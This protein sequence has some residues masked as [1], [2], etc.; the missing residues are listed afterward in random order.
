MLTLV[1]YA[2]AALLALLPTRLAGVVMPVIFLGQRILF[3]EPEEDLLR[4]GSMRI[5][6]VDVFSATLVLKWLAGGGLLRLREQDRGIRYV[7]GAWAAVNFLA[8]LAAG[9]KF[10]DAHAYACIAS[11]ARGLGEAIL[12]VVLADSFTS[13]RQARTV[14]LAILGFLGVLLAIQF[15]NYAGAD[16][17]WVIGEVQGLERDQVRIFG[18][19]GDSVGF[20]LL[21]GY[22]YGLCRENLIV[23]AAFAGGIVVTAG[24]GAVI[25]MAVAT[26]FYLVARPYLAAAAPRRGAAPLLLGLGLAA[27]AALVWTTPLTATLRERLSGA[28]EESGGQRALTARVALTMVDDNFW[29]GVGFMGFRHLVMRYGGSD[30]FGYDA[31]DGGT[32]NANN[33]ALQSLTDAGIPGIVA[34]AALIFVAARL[35]YRV[36]HRAGDPVLAAFFSAVMLWLLA[37]AFG[38]L[39]ATWLTPSSGVALLLWISLGTAAGVQRLIVLE[40]EKA[41]ARPSASAP[42]LLGVAP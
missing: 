34:L 22:V 4:L 12:V 36:A 24:L 2:L 7:L 18:P 21:L 23:A 41:D 27:A 14:A 11:L 13:L 42:Q 33:Q 25:S 10:G 17:G 30:Y 1:I 8:C 26:A 37:Q 31:A 16:R 32:A 6:L 39:A 20:I 3:P 35:L 5:S 29:T 15:F 9:L 38:N 19:V 28:Y 40:E